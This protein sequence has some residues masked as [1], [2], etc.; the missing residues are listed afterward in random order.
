MF[1]FPND[2][3]MSAND[4]ISTVYKCMLRGAADF[5]VKPIRKNELKNLWQHVWRR[6][7]VWFILDSLYFSFITNFA[8]PSY[9]LLPVLQSSSGGPQATSDAQQKVEATAEN[10]ATSNHSSGY[11]ACI[12]R[13]RECIEKG[14]DA[15]V[16]FCLL[17]PINILYMIYYSKS[18]IFCFLCRALAQNQM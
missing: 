2:A 12:Q 4:S 11:E 5:L 10:N 13:N 8:S 14:S 1:F 17:S 3:V 9:W 15:Q 18:L 16:V 6:Q 7:A